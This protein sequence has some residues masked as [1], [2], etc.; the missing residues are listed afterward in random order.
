MC[1][2]NLTCIL[3][4]AARKFDKYLVLWIVSKMRTKHPLLINLLF[5]H[6]R[7]R[8]VPVG[9]RDIERELDL[10]KQW[11]RKHICQVIMLEI[12]KQPAQ[13]TDEA[14]PSSSRLGVAR[15]EMQRNDRIHNLD[16]WG[17]SVNSEGNGNIRS[18]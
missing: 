10:H 1:M 4:I 17:T 6:K 16:V 13:S 11:L 7:M 14:L 12:G 18:Y 3:T 8:S 2:R 9:V 5:V 15:M